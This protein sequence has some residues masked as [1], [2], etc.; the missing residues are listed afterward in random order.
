[1]RLFKYIQKLNKEPQYLTFTDTEA[2]RNSRMK[3][4]ETIYDNILKGI[5]KP[6]SIRSIK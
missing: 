3:Q 1:M 5:K 4:L 2:I 6:D